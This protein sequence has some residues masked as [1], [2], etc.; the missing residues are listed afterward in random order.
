M[1]NARHALGALGEARAAA[2]FESQGYRILGRDVRRHSFKNHYLQLIKNEPL[3]DFLLD[4]PILAGWEVLRLGYA[5]LR[6]PAVLP[7][8][9]DA[10][11]LSG[12]AWDKRRLLRAAMRRC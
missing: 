12:R 2:H 1:I 3:R 6:D 4:L 10:W 7:G 9:L 11:R 5:V 8:Y